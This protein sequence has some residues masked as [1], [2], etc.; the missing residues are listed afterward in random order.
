MRCM[1]LL[2]G[3]DVLRVD[4]FDSIDSGSRGVE[5]E[6]GAEQRLTQLPAVLPGHVRGE[7]HVH[8]GARAVGEDELRSGI[9]GIDSA[10]MSTGTACT[11]PSR[12]HRRQSHQQSQ[13]PTP[14]MRSH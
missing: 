1:R 13:P 11:N 6:E 9:D 14:H 12:S 7:A 5:L 2:P 3:L 8:A 10:F 4:N